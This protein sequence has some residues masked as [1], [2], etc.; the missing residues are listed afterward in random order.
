MANYSHLK[1]EELLNL[2]DTRHASPLIAELSLRLEKHIAGDHVPGTT[3]RKHDC[4]VC[5]AKLIIDYD[6]QNE[7][8]ELKVEK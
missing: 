7:L 1:D 6:D 5:E 2:T 4:P 8:F 3:N